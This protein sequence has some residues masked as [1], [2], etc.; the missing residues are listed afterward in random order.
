VF[1][2][3]FANGAVSGAMAAAVSHAQSASTRGAAA[4]GSTSSGKSSALSVSRRRSG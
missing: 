1:G 3:K 2:G 4:P